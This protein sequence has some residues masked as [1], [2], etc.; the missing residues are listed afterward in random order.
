MDDGEAPPALSPPGMD[1]T[2]STV[3]LAGHP[4]HAMAVHFPI[5]LGFAVLACDGMLWWGG[6][7][8]WLRAGLWAAGGAFLAGAGAGVVGLAELLL[9]PGIRLR[10]SGWAHAVAGSVLIAVLGASW[11]LRLWRPEAVIGAGL[12]LS[13]LGAVMTGVAG[14]HGGKLIYHHGLAVLPQEESETEL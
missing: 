11:M 7:G 14:W 8:F 10:L 2:G 9:V 6:D 1:D 12:A 13:A 4:L 5:A 3:A